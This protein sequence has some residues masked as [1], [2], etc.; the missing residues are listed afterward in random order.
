MFGNMDEM[1]KKMR[2]QLKEITFSAEAGGG[3]IKIDANA[4]REILNIQIDPEFLKSTE[5]EELEDLLVV[6]LNNVILTATEKEAEQ[7]QNLLK[8]MMPP[9]L[10][11][12]SNLFG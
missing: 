10:G 4:A 9:G 2:E 6:A 3:A 11:G 8:D 7:T 1:Q 12:L 5:A